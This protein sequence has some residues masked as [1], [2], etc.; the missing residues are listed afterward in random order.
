[1]RFSNFFEWRHIYRIENLC[2]FVRLRACVGT[3]RVQI[4][5]ALLTPGRQVRALTPLRCE[6]IL[7]GCDRVYFVYAQSQKSCQRCMQLVISF[8]LSYCLR[9]LSTPIVYA[10]WRKSIRTLRIYL[11]TCNLV[12]LPPR[13]QQRLTIPGADAKAKP[14]VLADGKTLADF[15]IKVG[16]ALYTL[17]SFLSYLTAIR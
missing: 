10:H 6:S 13:P 14:V 17:F 4:K 16:G 9:P 12:F 5:G 15:D 2:A 8:G 3:S 7:I 1:M 11:H